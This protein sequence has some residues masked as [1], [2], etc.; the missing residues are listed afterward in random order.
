M[1]SVLLILTASRPICGNARS[2]A[3]IGCGRGD[4]G[5]HQL[6]LNP[7]LT[8]L[9][10]VPSGVSPIEPDMLTPSNSFCSA[11]ILPSHLSSVEERVWPATKLV[12]VSAM[13]SFAERST[14]WFRV[15]WPGE[16]VTGTI[17]CWMTL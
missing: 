4:V 15:G 5:D 9:F 17:P 16:P 6:R 14:S 10:V 3:G 2:F 13:L 8:L 11:P 7:A 1:P 12:P